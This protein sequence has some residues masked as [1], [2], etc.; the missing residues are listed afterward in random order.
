MNKNKNEY[1]QLTYWLL[2]ASNNIKNK[3]DNSQALNEAC[4]Y[5]D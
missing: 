2:E 3:E 5:I 1:T 4:S